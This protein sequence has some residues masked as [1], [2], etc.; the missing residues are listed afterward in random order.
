MF[1][2][3]PKNNNRQTPPRFPP[4]VERLSTNQSQSAMKKISLNK[5]VVPRWMIFIAD[6]LLV[7]LS[8]CI[9]YIITKLFQVDV[10]AKREFAV[11]TGLYCCVAGLVFYGMK[12]HTGLIRYSNIHDML[13]IFIA[14]F[15]T[16]LLYPIAVNLLLHLF[17]GLES[18]DLVRVLFI[19]FF[20][21]SSLL[22]FLRSSIKGM[23]FY[24]KRISSADMD[25]VL[26]YGTD[27]TSLM[28][29]QTLESSRDARLRIVGFLDTGSN[30]VNTHIQQIKVYQASSLQKIHSKCRIDKLIMPSNILASDDMQYILNQC[31]DLSIR[32]FTVPPAD[33][34]IYGKLCLTQL[35]DLKIE[36]LLQRDPINIK[37]PQIARELNGKRVLVTGAAGSI[38]NEIVRQVV[39]H[40]VAMIILCDQA[41]SALYD[42]QLELEEKYP[43]KK[44]V[45]FISS[46]QNHDRMQSLFKQFHPEIIFHAAAYKHVPMMEHHPTE[47][48]TTNVLGTK[49]IADLAVLFQ[50]EKFVMISTDKAVNPT[51]VM[52]G[53]K[54]IAE[55]YIQSLNNTFTTI[56]EENIPVSNSPYLSA[57]HPAPT[58][59]ITTRF[60]NVLG[61][62][63]SVIPR[64]Y[65]QIQSGGP[66]TITHP[67]MTRYFMTIPE[68]VQLV[69]EACTMGHGGEIFVFDMGKPVKILDLA[70]KMI[71]LAGLVPGKD[72][73]IEY[74]GLRPGEKL[75]EEVL[76]DKE[77]TIPTHHEKIKIAKVDQ[78]CYE[79][80]SQKVLDLVSICEQDDN[81][82]V[83]RKMKEIIPE[84]ISNN[85]AFEVLDGKK[86]ESRLQPLLA[87]V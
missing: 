42:I 51:N 60:G 65:R 56:G 38:G 37:N 46:I 50:A 7:G 44:I 48:I 13:R 5:T 33:Q 52:G 27:F 81:Y 72:I 66:V 55:M 26:I 39:E 80:I 15:S 18:L 47:A 17:S 41:E 85:S 4:Y 43:Q 82:V 1:T 78:Y 21:A 69:L 59:F 10:I 83:V 31:L 11:Y 9:A 79:D 54:R 68:A 23:Y 35:K 14:L 57:Y 64:F 45:V 84:Y 8:F 34:W 62:N 2:A 40:D 16:S 32:V 71:K 29:K 70:C 30:K 6:I 63:G 76:S 20:I 86:Q 75:Y 58:R 67:D 36:D 28:I 49:N 24:V 77:R 87:T 12:I 19:N 25:R 61:S 73:G 53:S 22:V 74:T 3:W